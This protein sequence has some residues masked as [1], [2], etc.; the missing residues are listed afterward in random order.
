MVKECR[1]TV[2]T[3]C[4]DSV[5]AA[6]YLVS[7]RRMH[8]RVGSRVCA[9]AP[10]HALVRA[11]ARAP[12]LSPGKRMRGGARASACAPSFGPH[13]T[14]RALAQAPALDFLVIGPRVASPITPVFCHIGM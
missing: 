9:S 6:A 1:Q 3:H 12:S 10:A 7:E 11:R 2:Y 14:A 4:P 8:F 5:R 13:P